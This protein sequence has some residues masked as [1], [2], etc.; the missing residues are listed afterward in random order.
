[1]TNVMTSAWE[2]RRTAATKWDCGMMDIIF[3]V[4]LK[5]AHKGEKIMNDIIKKIELTHA[6]LIK[7]AHEYD[8]IHNEG[9]EGYNPYREELARRQFEYE[10]NIVKSPEEQKYALLKEIAALD[11]SIAR[12][13][14]TYDAAKI[15]YLRAQ[16]GEIEAKQ[17]AEFMEAWTLETTK[18]RRLE[19]NAF[20]RS[21]MAGSKKVTPEIAQALTKKQRE[22]GWWMNDLKK[23]VKLHNL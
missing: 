18:K 14:G 5:M 19:W 15:A 6:Q 7:K 8:N 10:K 20:A 13:S 21:L 12:E 17:D 4:C 16:V 23:A 11:C 3:D 22:Q 1:M 2:I 9:G